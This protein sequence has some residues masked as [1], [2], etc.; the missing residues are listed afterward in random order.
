[1]TLTIRINQSSIQVL[2]GADSALQKSFERNPQGGG[3]LIG[4]HQYM[5]QLKK[6]YPKEEMA[7]LEPLTDLEYGELVEIMDAVRTLRKTDDAIFIKSSEG[8]DLKINSL[9]NKIFFSNIRS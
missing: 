3:D 7:I 1:M 5:I 9:F 4:L 8:R 6:R 2:T